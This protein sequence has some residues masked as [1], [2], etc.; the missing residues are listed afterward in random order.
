MFSIL[1]ALVLLCSAPSAVTQDS[2]QGAQQTLDPDPVAVAVLLEERCARCHEPDSGDEKAIKDWPDA[3][4]LNATLMIDLMVK[5]GDPEESD[6]FITC[7]EGDMPPE[8]EVE[9]PLDAAELALL[10]RWISAGASLP[11]PATLERRRAELKAAREE[12]GSPGDTALK[13]HFGAKT[14]LAFTG[15]LHM[16]LLHFPVALLVLAGLLSL[17]SSP[18]DR[19]L[20]FCLA[21]AAPFACLASISGWILAS[22]ISGDMDLHRWLGVACAALSVGALLATLKAWR[23]WR[24]LV[25]LTCVILI[26]AAHGGGDLVHGEDWL[27]LPI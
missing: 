3:T 21:A 24:P 19:L 18:P 17:R 8:D 6:L 2:D 9:E 12:A 5:P 20:K 26:A 4:D 1:T 11:N 22:E 15:R 23:I 14:W 10:A 25:L 16:T 7:D 13:R 27:R